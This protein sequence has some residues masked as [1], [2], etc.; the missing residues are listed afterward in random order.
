MVIKAK[1]SNPNR[2]E[3]FTEPEAKAPGLG[4]TMGGM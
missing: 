3:S 4:M 1:P 2:P